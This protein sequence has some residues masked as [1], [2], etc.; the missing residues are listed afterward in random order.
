[1]IRTAA[2]MGETIIRWGRCLPHVVGS[3]ADSRAVLTQRAGVSA[4]LEPDA[5]ADG[6]E[7]FTFGRR[8]LALFTLTP[9][10]RGAVLA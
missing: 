6:A 2:N 1:M 8:S 10:D 5:G 9:T 3:P 4:V 7:P